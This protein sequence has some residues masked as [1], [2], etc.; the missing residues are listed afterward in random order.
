MNL[1]LGRQIPR[2]AKCLLVIQILQTL[3][4]QSLLHK[5]HIWFQ[6]SRTLKQQNDMVSEVQV[7][8]HHEAGLDVP[9]LEAM[10][11]FPPLSYTITSELQGYFDDHNE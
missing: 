1:V 9:H 4:R 8:L 5:V 11:D 6:H 2:I 7:Q 3:P 10:V